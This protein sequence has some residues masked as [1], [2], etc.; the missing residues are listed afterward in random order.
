MQAAAAAAP[1]LLVACSGHGAF[2][3]MAPLMFQA[4]YPNTWSSGLLWV[5]LVQA[6]IRDI[7]DKQH[8]SIDMF[9]AVVV[10]WAVWSALQRVYPET[11]PLPQR[12]PAAAGD[13][14]HPLV[15]CVIGVAL[16]LAAIVIFVA[17]A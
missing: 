11:Q 15:L 3:V 6:S 2:W 1:C 7:V 13:R 12:P 10:T 17:K 8:Y 14:P 16:L 9:L 5:A 4:Y